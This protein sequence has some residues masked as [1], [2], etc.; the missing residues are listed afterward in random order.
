MSQFE[1]PRGLI[2]YARIETAEQQV[3]EVQQSSAVLSMTINGEIEGPFVWLRVLRGE[4]GAFAHLTVD[5]ARELHGAL[6][7]WLD[8][9]APAGA[10]AEAPAVEIQPEKE[11]A[12]V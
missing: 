6:G 12:N 10:G 3:V 1:G 7:A 8:D 11:W 4:S 9:F 5:D 2:G